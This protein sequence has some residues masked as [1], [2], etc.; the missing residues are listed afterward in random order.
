MGLE[1]SADALVKRLAAF[2]VH[3][4]DSHEADLED[5]F[6]GFYRDGGPDEG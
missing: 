3:G 1:G 5:V 6:L 4:I 2:E